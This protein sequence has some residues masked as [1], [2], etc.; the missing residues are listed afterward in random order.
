MSRQRGFTLI[1]LLVVIA[2]IAILMAILLPALNR[3]REQGKRAVCLNNLK[4][5]VLGWMMYCDDHAGNLPK[6]VAT[7]DENYG[8]W[9]L[10]PPGHYP[11]DA[12]P[13]V[14]IDAVKRGVLFKYVQNVGVYRCPVAKS[15]EK[16][17]YS[18]SHAMN[19]IDTKDDMGPCGGG[20]V[21]KNRYYIK[22]PVERIVY[23]DDYG[24]DWDAAWAIPWNRPF[25][26]NPIPARHGSGNTWSF[27]DGH[28]EYWKWEDPSTIKIMAKTD[29]WDKSDNI[30]IRQQDNRDMIRVQK[31]TWGSLGYEP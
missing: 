27:A 2:I 22:S 6:A 25:W 16:R 26:W 20:P 15:N 30:N 13:E 14:Q 18:C 17:T 28:A 7:E 3:A 10:K 19:G 5:L 12:L 21:V 1:E 29:W 8:S 4:T 11:V 9:I 23:L 31:A 24:E